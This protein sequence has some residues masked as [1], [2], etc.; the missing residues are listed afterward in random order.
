MLL[1][2][3][4]ILNSQKEEKEIFKLLRTESKNFSDS[5]K[6]AS[7]RTFLTMASIALIACIVVNFIPILEEDQVTFWFFSLILLTFT[8]LRIAIYF[9]V[10]N[11]RKVYSEFES[12]METRRKFEFLS[13]SKLAPMREAYLSGKLL[14]II[15]GLSSSKR[16]TLISVYVKKGEKEKSSNWYMVTLLGVMLFAVWTGFIGAV[17]EDAGSFDLMLVRFAIFIGISIVLSVFAIVYKSALE[18]EVLAK[19]FDYMLLAEIISR[20]DTLSP[21]PQPDPNRRR[22]HS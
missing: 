12:L 3:Q 6:N 16:Q 14:P 10:K 20:I 9:R 8:F 4:D 7:Y 11:A 21:N 15:L 17:I 2:N 19:S 13:S 5:T 18:K 22:V 1:T